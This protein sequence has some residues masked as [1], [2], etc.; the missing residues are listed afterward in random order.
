MYFLRIWT[1]QFECELFGFPCFLNLDKCAY[2]HICPNYI[3]NYIH[4]IL[5]LIIVHIY[6]NQGHRSIILPLYNLYKLDK[7]K[8]VFNNSKKWTLHL[9]KEGL[10]SVM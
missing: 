3:P 2:V 6:P 10:Q 4:V 8:P 1:K 5:R 7:F 9:I